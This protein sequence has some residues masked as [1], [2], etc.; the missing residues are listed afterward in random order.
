MHH[1]MRKILGFEKKEKQSNETVAND[2]EGVASPTREESTSKVS[3]EE[4]NTAARAT[5]TATWSAVFYLITTD[6]LGPG[7]VPWSL[8]QMGWTPGLVLYTIFGV[9]AL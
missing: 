8:S 7:S 4:W 3:Q 2:M 6:I 1:P 5:R 9:A